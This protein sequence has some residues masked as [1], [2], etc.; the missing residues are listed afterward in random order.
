MNPI[1]LRRKPYT[2]PHGSRSRGICLAR[3]GLG[4]T[5]ARLELLLIN[6]ASGVALAQDLQRLVASCRA[7]LA[8]EPPDERRQ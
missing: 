7:A 8:G 6:L 5:L 2:R 3:S 1:E 4:V